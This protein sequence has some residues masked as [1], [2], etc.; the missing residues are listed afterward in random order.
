MTSGPETGFHSPE[1]G[2]ARMEDYCFILVSQISF[3]LIR[4]APPDFLIPPLTLM[5][6]LGLSEPSPCSAARQMPDN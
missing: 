5:A 4:S 2:F 1:L 6:E 3:F